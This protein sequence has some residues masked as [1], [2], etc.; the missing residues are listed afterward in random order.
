MRRAI[1]TAALVA[2]VAVV[3]VVAGTGQSSAALPPWKSLTPSP[4][5]RTEVG[6]A[7]LGR[8][9]YVVGG[10]EQSTGQTTSAVLRYDLERDTWRR[11]RSL[12]IGVNH[13]AVAAWAGRLYVFGGYTDPRSFATFSAGLY[14]YDPRRDRWRRLR[15]APVA[16]A[17]HT[18]QAF[19]GRLYA[20]GGVTP[21]GGVSG[22]M[23]IYDIARRRWS[24]GPA[25]PAGPREHLASA[26]VGRRM[27]VLGG[28][29]GGT[30][31]ATAEAYE[32]DSRSWLRLHDMLRARGG[33]AAAAGGL[34]RVVAFG[35]EEAAGTI[36]EV[37]YYEEG[38]DAWHPLADMVT[39]RHGLGGVEWRHRVFAIEG[40]PQPGF[41]FSNAVEAMQLP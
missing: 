8:Y 2:A 15:D 30:N 32:P 27:Y 25:M 21:K 5:T 38:E 14:R 37:E 1:A 18:M 41:A 16:R 35:G 13:T 28:R 24:R 19:G 20:V 29:S 36:R 10:F 7:R 40:G 23:V 31:L 4:L 9:A 12:P 22:D 11:V 33:N 26:R 6:A 3:V 39:P 34:H 17:A